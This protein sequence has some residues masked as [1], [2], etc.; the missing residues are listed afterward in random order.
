MRWFNA[1][2]IPSLGKRITVVYDY[3]CGDV[4]SY[5]TLTG[6]FIK[7]YND[8]YTYCYKLKLTDNSDSV[9]PV[10]KIHAWAYELDT[11]IEAV[12]TAH[13]HPLEV[14]CHHCKEDLE[15]IAELHDSTF[16]EVP[17]LENTRTGDI[18][19]DWHSIK[20][21]SDL[22]YVC[23]ECKKKLANTFE[24]LVSLRKKR[25][26][27]PFSDDPDKVLDLLLLNKEEFLNSYSYITEEEYD[28]TV[29]EL[30][31]QLSK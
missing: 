25:K 28:A 12:K 3:Y 6:T 4:A 30:R 13:E 8:G 11:A 29:E 26:A 23:K 17:I 10:D 20:L 21:E 7:F 2:T 14:Y 1:D 27:K 9:F 22:K 31:T 5:R 18:R 16:A 24:E 15:V 19:H